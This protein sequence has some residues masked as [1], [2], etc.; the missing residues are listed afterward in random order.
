MTYL[1]KTLVDAFDVLF[2]EFDS[3]PFKSLFDA[4]PSYPFDIYHNEDGSVV[5]EVPV[6]GAEKS[7]VKII[8]ENDVLKVSRVKSEP[9]YTLRKYLVKKIAI[10]DFDLTFSFPN[11]KYDYTKIEATF[12]KGL[13]KIIVPKSKEKDVGTVEVKIN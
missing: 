1:N 10:R 7:D 6:I 2:K 13:L 3:D 9:L 8:V 11:K 5:V 4:K 12:D